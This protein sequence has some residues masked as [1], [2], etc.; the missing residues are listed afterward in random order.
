[1]T[2]PCE[3]GGIHI[4]GPDDD[5]VRDML[6]LVRA[7]LRDDSEGQQAVLAHADLRGL[8]H[9]LGGTLAALLLA[10]ARQGE[11]DPDTAPE[12]ATEHQLTIAEAILTAG[13]DGPDPLGLLEDGS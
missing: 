13:L 9:V 12:A 7:I 6:A 11:T 8:A 3:H 2:G 5:S 10:S 4:H 1:M